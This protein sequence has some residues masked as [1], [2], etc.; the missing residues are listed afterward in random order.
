MEDRTLSLSEVAGLMGVSERTIRR[1][2]QAGRLKAYKPGRD[3]RI[4]ESALR[5]FVE[6]SE[7]SPKALAPP[8]LFNG[9]E[10]ERRGDYGTGQRIL[11][12]LGVLESTAA[13][14]ERFLSDELYDLEKLNLEQ[15]RVI[16]RLSINVISDYAQQA[17]E[18][19]R[20]SAP[21]LRER[22]EQAEQRI[23]RASGEFWSKVEETLKRQ[24]VPDLAKRR[25]EVQ[26][27]NAELEAQRAA[28]AQVAG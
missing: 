26:D 9:L 27:R 22:L 4:P 16:D 14:W 20:A 3:Y 5:Q 19:K 2:I 21:E 24:Q 23:F 25:A 1:W 7:I 18:L 6:E 11:T 10:E 12:R 15:L 13:Q 8:S 17:R 28:L